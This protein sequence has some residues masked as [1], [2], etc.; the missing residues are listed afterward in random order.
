VSAFQ[1]L[2]LTKVLI[3][4]SVHYFVS[5]KFVGGTNGCRAPVHGSWHWPDR[6]RTVI[7]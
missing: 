3:F 1:F 7:V 4:I 5:I 2:I 6:V